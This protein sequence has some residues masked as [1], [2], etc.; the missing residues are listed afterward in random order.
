M[1]QA[2]RRQAAAYL[3]TAATGLASLGTSYGDTCE[4]GTVDVQGEAVLTR[5][6]SSVRR[7]R[8]RTTAPIARVEAVV[9]VTSPQGLVEASLQLDSGSSGGRTSAGVPARLRVSVPPCPDAEGLTTGERLQQ[10]DDFM[11]AVARS[12]RPLDVVLTLRFDQVSADATVTY[13]VTAT[14]EQCRPS[15]P[16]DYGYYLELD[17]L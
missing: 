2:T 10:C 16:D 5:G 6:I 17:T 11:A 15:P 3:A 9:E 4:G 12:A 8:L 7:F 13:L 1:A 14:T